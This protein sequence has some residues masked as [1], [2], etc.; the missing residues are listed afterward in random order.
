[1]T[2]RS[3]LHVVASVVV[4]SGTLRSQQVDVY[5]RPLRA[6]RSHDFDVLHYR[7][8]LELALETRSYAGVAT[9]TMRALRSGF[10]SCTLDAETFIVTSVYDRPDHP[11]KFRQDSGQVTVTFTQPV[12]YGDT[13]SF[14]LAYV[15]DS[16]DVEGVKY[17]MGAGYDLGLSFKPP[18]DRRSAIINTLSFPT[19][20][21]H[22]FPC[23]DHPNDKA[24]TEV[25]ATV[26]ERFSVLSNG[27]LLSVRHDPKHRRKTFHWYQGLPHSTYLSVLVAGEY[28]VI[29]DSLDGL[30]IS[31][32]V[33]P[34]DVSHARR[35][36]GRT[37]EIIGFYERLFGI[38]YPWVKYDQITIPGIGG[39]A[40]STTATVIGESAVIDEAAE[41]DFPSEWL[42]AHE[43][44]H[45]W[46]GD[47]VTMR[48]WDQTW[49]NESFATYYEYVWS[50]HSYGENEGAWNLE[51][52]RRQYYREADTKYRRP[53][54]FDRWE[55]PNENFD[56]HTYPKGAAVLHMLREELGAEEFDASIRHFLL[57]HPFGSVDTRDL[58]VAIK[59]ATGRVMDPF[60]DQWVYGAG[61]P[62]LDVAWSWDD[63]LLDV[64]LHVRQVHQLTEH[65]GLFSF[66][67]EIGVKTGQGYS[68]ERVYVD[69]Q[70]QT[71]RLHT[72]T[73]PEFLRFD[74]GNTLLARVTFRT[75]TEEEM[76]KLV[77]ADVVGKRK[78]IERLAGH[79]Q[80]SAVVEALEAAG[81]RD[82]FWRVRALAVRTLGEARQGNESYFRERCRDAASGVRAEAA[83][84]L[85]QVGDKG[86]VP[87]L[88][89]LFERET[90]YLVK[91]AIIRSVGRLD[92]PNQRQ[93]LEGARHMRSFR[94]VLQRAAEDALKF[95]KQEQEY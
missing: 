19:G 24:T 29:S 34:S 95:L 78:A 86:T 23:Y 39:G 61:H 92:G 52:K 33:Y 70:N 74:E 47:Y 40:E 3:F 60:F 46:W 71:F 21:R 80:A 10:D 20:A 87:F 30:P 18:T 45:Q 7:I 5:A 63:E 65:V 32:W 68:V 9:V 22:W 14:S 49:M 85:G 13:L 27:E 79:V 11:L 81:R 62:D 89:S 72:D 59:Q 90:S 44:A 48:D 94:T 38:P 56:S 2:G 17:G 12:G 54:V 57:V 82:A 51:N 16:V 26:D 37:P 15:A 77:E 28:A 41:Q 36:F 43:A 83:F 66:P 42:V 84:S 75:S 4:L 25:I 53:I 69:R 35:T 31:Y 76:L 93:F 50:R 6:E 1:M 91:A 73:R 64:V 67:V 88:L 8:Q 58:L 55:Y